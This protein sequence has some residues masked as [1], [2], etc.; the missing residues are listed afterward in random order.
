[1]FER[2]KGARRVRE[3]GERL[4]GKVVEAARTPELYA[5]LHVPD[6]PNGRFECIALHAIVVIRRLQREGDEGAELAQAVFDAMFRDMDVSSREMGVGDLAV[7]KRI[8][9]MAQAFYGRAKAYGAALD[10]NDQEGLARALGRNIF[11]GVE[12]GNP[13]VLADGA[14]GLETR[15][16]DTTLTDLKAGAGFQ[17]IKV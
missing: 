16:L 15:L 7:G 6:T 5:D 11:E 2:F 1:M 3:A 13:V 17:F 12:N 4:Y 10:G 8:K 9:A 14:F